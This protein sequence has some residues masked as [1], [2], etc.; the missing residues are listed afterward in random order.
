MSRLNLLDL[1]ADS[2]FFETID[3]YQP[4]EDGLVELVKS[5]L[6]DDWRFG[7]N[8]V[9][10]GCHPPEENDRPLPQQGWKIHISS[11]ITNADEILKAV[12]PVLSRNNVAF[13]FSLDRRLLA[14]MHSKGW[15][16]QG[17]GKFI[18]VYP[19][20]EEHFKYLVEELYR[21]TRQFEGLYI[22][23]DK[24]YKDSR[25]I[26]YRYGGIRPFTF[27]NVKGENVSVLLSPGGEKVPDVR[28]PYFHVPAWAK[29]PF[30]AAVPVAQGETAGSGEIALKD[31]RYVVK[32][33]LNFSNSGGVYVAHDRETGNDVVIKEARPCVT[34]TEDA[35]S[36]L[37]KEH[38]ILSKI[39]HTGVAPQ[40]LDFFQDWE[41]FFLVQE[42]CAGPTL[43]GFAARNNITL[44][45]HPTVENTEKFYGDFKI[46]FLQLARVIKVMHE[47]N[48]ILTDL[49]PNN[50]IVLP[51][52]KQIKL[53]D[54]E[55]AYELEVD[56]PIYMYTPGF[57]YADQM[58]GRASTFESDYFSF[59][60]VMHHF[61]APVNQI[62][63]IHPRARYKFI[64]SVTKDI[65]FPRSVYEII[66][67]LIDKEAE[68]RPTPREVI[69]VL[70]REETITAPQFA[71]E[72]F[73]ADETY[74]SWVDGICEYT[75]S[76]A[77]YDR[78][79]RLF[80]ADAKVFST[81]PLSIAHGAC[82]VAQVMGK[83]GKKV[84]DSVTDWILARNKNPQLYPPGLYLGLAGIAWAM[85]DMGL[86]REARDVLVSTYDHPLLYDSPDL[87]YGAAG[88]GLANLKFF[89]ET[90]DEMYLRKAEEAGGFLLSTAEKDERGFYWK[91]DG[92]IPL[93]YGHGPSGI[94]AFLLYLYLAGGEEKFLETGVR[95][96]D[97]DLNNATP[98][99]EDG[100]SWKRIADQGNIMYPYWRY[101]SAGVGVALLRYHRL[102]GEERYKEIL[103]KI[104]IDTNRK[105]AVYPGFLIGLSGLGEF[106]LD[107]YESTKESRHLDGAYRVAGGL[108]LFKIEKE[109]GVAFPG[110][111]LRRISCDYGTGSAG[112]GHFLHRLTRRTGANLL[113]D[114]LFAGDREETSAESYAVAVPVA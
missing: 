41:H 104:Y 102:L 36:L 106:L 59:G 110:D 21:V 89:I 65:G 82:G 95:A 86:E 85:L 111:T 67:A 73:E 52:T 48:I 6:P 109:P 8:T 46:L 98:N 62:F 18:T 43:G 34:A 42:Y 80:P 9:W 53:I 99:L 84:P 12:V 71:V 33:V 74:E 37:K 7:R 61:L 97:F 56:Q 63:L 113:L 88:W 19:L 112:V 93:G 114:Q 3:Y 91:S 26:F 22:L 57:A 75:L 92:E 29:D 101:G 90:Q 54:F 45:T 55:G 25:V 87:Y 81:N 15:A 50:V 31:G 23:S 44:H 4:Q 69:E 58:A 27:L 32:S 49:S 72:R 38:R 47:N 78:R 51:E 16:R 108:S 107:L 76:V 35:I 28:R 14:L 40:P 96:L 94:S 103:E 39:A 83:V 77:D 11:S 70:E 1:L 20:D 10:L 60:A 13:K 2:L 30:E 100:L 68:K 66:S 5:L 105:Y 17:A 64:D 79:D 24:R